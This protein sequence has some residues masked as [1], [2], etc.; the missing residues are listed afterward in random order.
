MAPQMLSLG[1]ERLQE[2]MDYLAGLG[3]PREKLPA[4]IARVPQCLGLSS[5]RIQETVDTVDKM[6]GEG[7]GVRALMRNSRIVM[8]N[9]NGI[10]RSFDYLSSLGM[11]KDRIEK[12]IRFIMRSVSGILRPRAQFLKA[13]GVDVVDDVTW[14]LMSEERFIKKCPDFAAY[15]TAYKARLKKKSKPKE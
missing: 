14:I 15:V 8:H 2:N 13:K 10:R 12:C 9:V 7:A 11:P 6:F 3:I 5:S 4:I 1:I